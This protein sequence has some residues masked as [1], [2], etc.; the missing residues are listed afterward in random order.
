MLP[1]NTNFVSQSPVI[2]A[3][4]VPSPQHLAFTNN[5]P[6]CHSLYSNHPPPSLFS[7]PSCK[8]QHN[9]LLFFNYIVSNVSILQKSFLNLE[10]CIE[11]KQC[12]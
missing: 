9:C 1:E 10:I 3:I 8:N 7:P 5:V 11:I 6:L 2:N 12:L 4:L